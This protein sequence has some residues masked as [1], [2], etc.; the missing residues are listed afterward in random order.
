MRD[1]K[2]ATLC[3]HAP[4]APGGFEALSSPIHRASTVVFDTPTAFKNRASKV[5]D[6]Y[7]YGLYGTPSTRALEDQ[8]A[9]LE[10]GS[11][12]LVLPSGLAA[13]A[14]AT[15]ASVQS[16]DTIL[17]PE[18]FYGPARTLI[19]SLLS[20]F[21]INALRYHG[22]GLREL[23]DGA[24]PAHRLLWVES[25]GSTTFEVRDVDKMANAARAR[26]MR[27]AMDN[28]W[29]TPLGFQPLRHGVDMSMQSLSKYA[30][31]HS[32]VL[33]GSL[34]FADESLYRR[35]K[36][37]ARL[38]GYGVSGEDCFLVSRGLATMPLRLE[39]SVATAAVLMDQLAASAE[40]TQI[41]HP[42][43]TEHP[44]HEIFVRDYATGAGIFGVVLRADLG[45]GSKID[46][47]FEALE[48]F[49]IGASWGGAHSLIAPSDPKVGR[50]DLDWLPDGPYL[51]IAVG[52]EDPEDLAAD[53]FRFL[54]ALT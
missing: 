51:R 39:R 33:M 54:D 7:S 18:G 12:A 16:G 45:S 5:Y 9:Q 22:D 36:D 44:G 21:G 23:S 24:G 32:D 8:I 35:T 30:S 38:L 37:V 52:L 15:I 17:L 43:R 13:I 26:G 47:A 10:G 3:V 20:R 4:D 29:A 53:L 28:T 25:P 48:L 50:G 40:V 41:L 19:E 49:K 34:A 2:P 46:T 42:S 1:H 31:G 11:R 6:G 14:V 27:V